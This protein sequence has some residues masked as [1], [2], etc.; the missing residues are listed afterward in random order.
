MK[1]LVDEFA[2]YLQSVKKSSNNTILSY[3]RDLNKMISFMENRGVFDIN[4]VTQDRLFSY[5]ES[6]QN[7]HMSVSSIPILPAIAR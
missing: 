7:E 2:I 6:L 4:E 3:K 5:V 1:Q